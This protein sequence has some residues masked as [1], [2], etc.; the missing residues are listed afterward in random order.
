M[1]WDYL[2]FLEQCH[3][4]FFSKG[5][6]PTIQ[7]QETKETAVHRALITLPDFLVK[8]NRGQSLFLEI[9]PSLKECLGV[10]DLKQ[11][12]PIHVAAKFMTRNKNYNLY[13][14]LLIKMVSV[15][16]TMP[17]KEQ[18]NILNAMNSTGDTSLHILAA[19]SKSF[20]T[21]QVLMDA[22]ADS[23]LVNKF[24]ITPLDVAIQNGTGRNIILLKRA[25]LEGYKK[26]AA[27]VP[28]KGCSQSEEVKIRRSERRSNNILTFNQF[29][30]SESS[31]E[32]RVETESLED[33][34]DCTTSK[35]IKNI[36]KSTL[37]QKGT[38]KESWHDLTQV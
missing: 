37:Q 10:G 23:L 17:E 15:V 3:S 12:T 9:L 32:S 19:S 34:D 4:L 31:P 21:M 26:S 27:C 25:L 30:E 7:C 33:Q 14:N 36:E 1:N 24:S 13:E 35:D 38:T 16:Q 20:N 18:S 11:D 28:V 5:F 6:N 22:G 2:C 8:N 29:Y